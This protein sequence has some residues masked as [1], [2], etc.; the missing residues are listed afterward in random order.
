MNNQHNKTHKLTLDCGEGVWRVVFTST[1]DNPFQVA[2]VSTNSEGHGK[3]QLLIEFSN[4]V[5]IDRVLTSPNVDPDPNPSSV[6]LKYEL[7]RVQGSE[8]LSL[9]SWFYEKLDIINRDFVDANEEAFNFICCDCISCQRC[10]EYVVVVTPLEIVNARI[11]LDNGRIAAIKEEQDT[12]NSNTILRCGQGTGN[13]LYTNNSN[14]PARLANITIP[15]E[16][17]AK[18][19]LDFSTTIQYLESF[20]PDSRVNLQFELFRQRDNGEPLSRGTWKYEVGIIDGGIQV[21]QSFGFLFCEC[22][23]CPGIYGYFIMVRILDSPS[24][25]LGFENIAINNSLLNATVE[26]K[27]VELG[28]NNLNTL[29]LECGKG[30]GRHRFTSSTDQF[31][32]LANVS[33]DSREILINPTINLLFSNTITYRKEGAQNTALIGVVRYQLIRVCDDAPPEVR[34]IWTIARRGQNSLQFSDSF[35]FSFC[36]TLVGPINCCTYYVE[37]SPIEL[38]SIDAAGQGNVPVSIT[39]DNSEMAALISNRIE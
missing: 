33:V 30:T 35:G 12:T 3:S 18:V 6:R 39:L 21:I 24:R 29:S 2:H 10:T 22:I 5:R 16:G 11:T 28:I 23:D 38:D 19:N 9:G 8:W 34:G 7:M 32:Q 13:L 20:D 15:V 36:D 31:S 26:L 27:E 1:N 4:L 25:I 37:A 14:P 17:K